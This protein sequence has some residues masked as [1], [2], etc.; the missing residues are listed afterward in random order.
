MKVK[1]THK[2]RQC[3]IC[4]AKAWIT[5]TERGGW[6]IWDC[7]KCGCEKHYRTS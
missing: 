3:P 2:K 1:T 4:K 6:E 7:P 5:I